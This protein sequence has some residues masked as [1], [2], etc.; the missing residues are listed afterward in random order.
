MINFHIKIFICKIQGERSLFVYAFADRLIHQPINEST[1]QRINESTI[2][3]INYST[4]EQINES[5]NGNY[6]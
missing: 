4:D 2:Q 1:N 6:G 3:R 5:T